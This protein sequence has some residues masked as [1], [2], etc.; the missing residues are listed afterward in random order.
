MERADDL[1]EAEFVE[2][3]LWGARIIAPWHVWLDERKFGAHVDQVQSMPIKVIASCHAPTM[4]GDRVDRAFELLHTV[5]TADP[6]APFT[7]GDLDQWMSAATAAP[8]SEAP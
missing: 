4:S 1:T 3:Q 8:V 5:P 2:G 7:Q 6:W